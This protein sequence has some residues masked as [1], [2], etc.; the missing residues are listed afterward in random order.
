MERSAIQGRT[1]H[2]A[3]LPA[4]H[5][6]RISLR[7][8]RATKAPCHLDSPCPTVKAGRM[9]GSLSPSVPPAGSAGPDALRTLLERPIPAVMGVLNITPDSFSDGGEFIAPELALKRA[10]AMIADGV[11]IIDIGAESTRPYTGA[12]AVTAE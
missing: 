6:T 7:S 10:R 12:N 8:M 11:D 4:R 5:E 1:I 3:G 2:I 9:N